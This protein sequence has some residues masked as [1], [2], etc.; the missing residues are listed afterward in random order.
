MA[1]Y[2]T[3]CETST[4]KLS[5]Q[6]LS[7]PCSSV[8]SGPRFLHP[9]TDAWVGSTPGCNGRGVQSIRFLSFDLHPVVALRGHVVVPF[10]GL[11]EPLGFSLASVLV[12]TPSAASRTPL[13]RVLA[14]THFLDN[15]HPSRCE[16]IHPVALICIFLLI[17]NVENFSVNPLAIRTSVQVRFNWVVCSLAVDLLQFSRIFDTNPRV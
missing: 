15:S 16:M 11:G 5:A 12:H 6:R 4:V 10:A 9:G 13:L 1:Q 17:S 8:G 14:N 2:C 7:S 3:H